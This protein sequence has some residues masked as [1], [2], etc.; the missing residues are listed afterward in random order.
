MIIIQI[1]QSI[2]V[3]NLQLENAKV[4]A[5]F[6]KRWNVMFFKTEFFFWKVRR[7]ITECLLQYIVIFYVFLIIPQIQAK[8][9]YIAVPN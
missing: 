5:T 9:Q 4:K 3:G 1:K 6:S 7:K 2:F 8:I